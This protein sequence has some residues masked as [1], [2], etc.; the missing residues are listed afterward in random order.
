VFEP[1]AQRLINGA[2]HAVVASLAQPFDYRGYIFVQGE[3]RPH[4]TLEIG[5]L[6]RVRCEHQVGIDEFAEFSYLSACVAIQV[7]ASGSMSAL[8]HLQRLEA[9]SIDILREAVSESE[10]PV[11]LYSIGKD[12]SVML[13][14]ATKAFYPSEPPFPLLHVDTT[15]SF[16][17]CTSFAESGSEST[18]LHLHQG[19]GQG[20][21]NANSK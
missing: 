19:G 13:H 2:F 21:E 12:S 4:A 16:V 14:L 1:F 15:W 6:L 9:E 20:R 3:G 11:M 8:T 10:R 17:K 5:E 18:F 7:R